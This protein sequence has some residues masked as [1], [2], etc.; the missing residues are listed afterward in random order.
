MPRTCRFLSLIVLVASIFGA[1]LPVF[2]Q[3]KTADPAKRYYENGQA[4][5]KQGEFESAI[6]DFSKAIELDPK[7]PLPYNARG[8]ARVNTG[9]LDDAIADF[10]QAITLDPTRRVPFVNRAAARVDK[11]DL[12]GAIADCTKAIALDQKNAAIVYRNRGC[13]KQQKGDLDG[14]RADYQQAIALAT[15]EAAYQRFYLLLLGLQQKPVPSDAEFKTVVSKWKDG[16]KKSVGRFLVGELNEDGLMEQTSQG[17]PKTVREQK[18]EGS[19]YAGAVRLAK[20]DR[21]GA[22]ALFERCVA[23]QLHTFPEFQFARAELA[24]M[25]KAK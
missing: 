14:A 19:Y 9:A 17:T 8:L 21:A 7:N 16:W 5:V 1:D 20:G 6:L 23:T 22:R 13:V 10:T 25:D 12:D 24:K 2:G 11:G 4:W 3:E 18:C 15:D